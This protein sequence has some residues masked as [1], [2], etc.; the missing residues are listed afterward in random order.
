MYD[1]PLECAE[2]AA[3]VFQRQNWQW[4][5][6]VTS[7]GDGMH[8]TGNHVPTA[9]EILTHLYKL[10][11]TATTGQTI[12]GHELEPTGFA[13]GGRFIFEKEQYGHEVEPRVHYPEIIPEPPTEFDHPAGRPIPMMNVNQILAMFGASDPDEVVPVAPPEPEP[14]VDPN[15]PVRIFRGGDD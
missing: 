3:E 14:E 2:R 15:A 4:S 12:K 8:F 5:E 1:S 13:S 10:R 9:T 7:D 11:E 6:G